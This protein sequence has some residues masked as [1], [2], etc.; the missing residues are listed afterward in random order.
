VSAGRVE[1][2]FFHAVEEGPIEQAERVAVDAATGIEGDFYDDL[3]LFEAEAVEGLEA[4]TGI[5]LGPGE[6]RRNVMTRGIALNDLVGH[7]FRVGD[8]EA[9]GDERCDP[10]RHLESLTEPGVLRG[11][12]DRGGLRASIL[13]GGSIAVG[14]G[15]E[16]LGPAVHPSSHDENEDG[17]GIAGRSE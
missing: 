12:V 8:V 16:D 1:G 7:R 13:R 3:T 14:D 17:R 5:A 15:V 4:D 6:I 10:C 2:I 11:L 9:F